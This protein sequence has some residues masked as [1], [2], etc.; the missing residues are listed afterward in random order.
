VVRNRTIEGSGH[1]K[2]VII[3]TD[4]GDDID[5]ALALAL[6]LS[7]P[8]LEVIAITTVYGRVDIRAKLASR[9]LEAYNRL[10]IPVAMGVRRPLFGEESTHIPN[11]APVLEDKNFPNIVDKH[12]VDLI[13]EMLEREKSL[14]IV[15]LGPLTNIALALLKN[16]DAFKNSELVIM[17]GCITRPVAEYNIKTD[18]EAASIVFSS[19]LP[20]T[21][22]GLDVTLKCVM[23]NEMLEL[24]NKS[25]KPQVKLLKKFIGLWMR[26]Y[27]RN[28]ILHD[29]LTVAVSF[30]EEIVEK[31]RKHVVVELHGKYTRGFT[32]TLPKEE[33]NANVCIGVNSQQ[34]LELYE[35]RVLT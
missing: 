11:Q 15:T 8:E 31:A 9:I 24:V 2:K 21:L 5:D 23:T 17:G 12:A 6:A 28:P 27:K 3:D 25:P 32:V 13:I 4:I 10:D 29:P 34:F 35:S 16:R 33:P 14:T 19:G 18:P 20:M 22:V 26:I 1:L 30:N 7:S